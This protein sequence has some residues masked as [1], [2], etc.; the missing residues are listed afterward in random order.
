MIQLK[1]HD[2]WCFL[3]PFST[4][5]LDIIPPLNPAQPHMTRS[6]IPCCAC[7]IET[8]Q[9]HAPASSFPVVYL[10]GRMC[11][12]AALANALFS[13]LAFTAPA[14]RTCSHR[15]P[16][17]NPHCPQ[18][19]IC[20]RLW[21]GGACSCLRP[22][23]VLSQA[24]HAPRHFNRRCPCAPPCELP[25]CRAVAAPSGG[26]HRALD[27]LWTCMCNTT[28]RSCWLTGQSAS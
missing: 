4:Q 28:G 19:P 16:R 20:G 15:H 18:V 3:P 8:R 5:N 22:A 14:S 1:K 27:W 13:W 25:Q 9:H 17:T 10:S 21:D 23:A 24:E 26:L 12:C 7:S 11:A 6:H 2:F